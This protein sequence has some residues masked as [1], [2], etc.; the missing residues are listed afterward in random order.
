MKKDIIEIFTVVMSMVV[1]VSA[2]T[3]CAGD[4]VSA[5]AKNNTLISDTVP[6]SKPNDVEMA[7]GEMVTAKVTAIDG[8]NITIQKSEM[9]EREQGE[10]SEDNEDRKPPT[11]GDRMS[12]DTESMEKP[13]DREMTPPENASGHTPPEMK[14]GGMGRGGNGG[15]MDFAGETETITVA[16]DVVIKK[17]G[18]RKVGEENSADTDEVLTIADI[19]VDDVVNILYDG[20]EI[21]EIT[22]R[23]AQPMEEQIT[24][25]VTEVQQ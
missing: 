7:M 3:A 15:N 13:D 8:N 22:I 18:P 4:D 2:V 25:D 20:D 19:L 24:E 1:M 14:D 9:P 11:D 17:S 5:G 23:E 6:E 12:P 16:D 21:K 10:M